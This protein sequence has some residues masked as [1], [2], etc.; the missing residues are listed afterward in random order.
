M[1]QAHSKP[2]QKVHRGKGGVGLSISLGD[3]SPAVQEAIFAKKGQVKKERMQTEL[4][5]GSQDTACIH[6]PSHPPNTS[7]QQLTVPPHLLTESTTEPARAHL[8]QWGVEGT[9]ARKSDPRAWQGAGAEA[10]GVVIVLFLLHQ[11]SRTPG[12]PKPRVI[13]ARSCQGRGLTVERA[14]FFAPQVSVQGLP[15]GR[16]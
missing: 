11:T 9:E 5:R 7:F 13:S 14:L 12:R 8:A 16:H 15:G 2:E 6:L 10:T 3:I 1:L 4:R